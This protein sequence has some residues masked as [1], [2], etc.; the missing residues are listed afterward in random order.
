MSGNDPTVPIRPGGYDGQPPGGVPAP[1]EYPSYP[2]GPGRRHTGAGFVGVA[3]VGALVAG[4]VA[5]LGSYVETV[6][7][8][9]N[10][11]LRSLG[12]STWP[13]YAHNAVPETYRLFG[14]DVI[15]VIVITFLLLLLVARP[16]PGGRSWFTVFFATW[17]VV[18]VAAVIAHVASVQVASPGGHSQAGYFQILNLAVMWGF[19]TGWLPAAFAATAN[20]V[21]R[22]AGVA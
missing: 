18:L 1:D 12:L 15:G 10:P 13:W 5:C 7:N 3:T 21:R 4:A 11:F 16:A 8:P 17:A 22:G 20:A 14:I 9:S 6:L 19:I 2:P